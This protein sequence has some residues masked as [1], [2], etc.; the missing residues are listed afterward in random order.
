MNLSDFS[1]DNLDRVWQALMGT[2]NGLTDEKL[3]WRPGVEA[4]PIGF[5]LWHQTRCEDTYIHSLIRQ[6][7]QV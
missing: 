2:V 1:L 4:N 7:P 5:V 3:A 6:E